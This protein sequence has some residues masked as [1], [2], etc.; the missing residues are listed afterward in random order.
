MVQANFVA[1]NYYPLGTARRS[2]REKRDAYSRST[3]S[4]LRHTMPYQA[5]IPETNVELQQRTHPPSANRGAMRKVR[6]LEISH[7]A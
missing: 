6:S 1:T 4:M 3:L 2:G 7:P 5:L